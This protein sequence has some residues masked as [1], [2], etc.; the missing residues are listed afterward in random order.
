MLIA[1]GRVVTSETVHR[2]GWVEID[3]GRVR[4]LGA[5]TPPRTPDRAYPEHTIVPGFVDIHVHGGGGSDYPDGDRG[6]ALAARDAHRARGTTRTMASL[7]TADRASLL[8]QVERLAPLVAAGELGGIHLEGPWLSQKRAGAHDVAQLRAPDPAEIDA[9]LAAADGAIRM[10]TIAPELPGALAA[11]ERLVGAGVTVALGHTDADYEQTRAALAAGATVA[12]HLFNAMP[13]LH[14]REPG[15]ILALLEDSRVT[16]ELIADGTHLHPSLAR[17]IAERVGDERVALVTDAMGAAACGDGDYRLGE[18]AVEVRKGV[19]KLAGT[20][21]IA[22]ST[23]TMDVLFRIAAGAG[24]EAELRAAVRKTSTTPA[25]AVG[26]ADAGDLAPGLVAD[27]VVLDPDLHVAAV[28]AVGQILG[29][30][31]ALNAR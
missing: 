16:V 23:V 17:W 13:A 4:A 2:P 29:D 10:V 18:L 21:T 1:A 14:H 8:A 27:L 11:I 22:G 25:R 5:G 24:S 12:T 3:A 7:V 26:W 15:P 19:A 6:G 28:F 9:L 31:A 20:E 30:A